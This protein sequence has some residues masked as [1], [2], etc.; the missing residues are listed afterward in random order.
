M[1]NNPFFTHRPS[2]GTLFLLLINWTGK[3]DTSKKSCRV[4]ILLV[5]NWI[6]IRPCLRITDAFFSNSTKR[7][8]NFSFSF[9]FI[10]LF[11]KD[12]QYDFNYQHPRLLTQETR[13]LPGDALITECTYSTVGR[14]KPT[15]GGYSTSNEMCLAFIL[16][17]PRTEL[18][19]CY[20]MPPV[21]FFFDTYGV[22][23]FYGKGEKELK[24]M[25]LEAR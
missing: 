7:L 17:Y 23:E 2:I 19:G 13:I 21:K 3:R 22:R 25:F 5:K 6:P 24:H 16:H 4:K 15:I 11:F 10:Y 18:T 9:Y 1:S 20:S 12:N 8:C 14:D